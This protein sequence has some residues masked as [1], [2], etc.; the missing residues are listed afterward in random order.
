MDATS[1]ESTGTEE[2]GKVMSSAAG[3]FRVRCVGH[4]D[5]APCR[6]MEERVWRSVGRSGLR[7]GNCKPLAGRD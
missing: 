4:Q 3:M 5:R 1:R 6:Q 2:W 7:M